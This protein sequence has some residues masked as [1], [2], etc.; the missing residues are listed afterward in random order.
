MSVSAVVHFPSRSHGH[1]M[2]DQL[3]LEQIDRD[4][5]TIALL[6]R[7]DRDVTIALLEWIDHGAG[8][9]RP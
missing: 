7:T 3:L 9:D 8:A 5:V 1:M 2:Q 6:E 4:A